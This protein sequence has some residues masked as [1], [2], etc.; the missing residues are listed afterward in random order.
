VWRGPSARLANLDLSL[1]VA[2]RELVLPGDP[3]PIVEKFWWHANLDGD[4][5]HRWFREALVT[6]MAKP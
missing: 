3:E 1:L 2:L 4:P 6:L 5:A